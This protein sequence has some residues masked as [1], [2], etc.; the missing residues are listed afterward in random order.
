MRSRAALAACA[1]LTACGRLHFDA[2][3]DGGD[4]A[5]SHDAS[6]AAPAFVQ[7]TV[8]TNVDG[9]STAVMFPSP[10]AANDTILAFAWSW[11]PNAASV[12]AGSVSDSAGSQ[13]AVAGAVQSMP[14]TCGGMAAGGAVFFAHAS[15]AIANDTVTFASNNTEN[16]MVAIEYTSLLVPDLTTSK[17]DAAMGPPQQTFS[18]DA[19]VTTAAPE[20]L[21][22]LGIPCSGGGGTITWV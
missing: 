22:S 14:G 5:T 19:L 4:G 8:T 10:I 12:P 9:P 3:G 6:D 21:V 15:T 11:G 16:G 17:I 1:T 18:T 20:L 7:A 13:F 2:L